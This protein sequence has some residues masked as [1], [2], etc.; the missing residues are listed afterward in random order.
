MSDEQIYDTQYDEV[1]EAE[2]QSPM[3]ELGLSGLNRFGSWVEEEW[4][5]KL[6][7]INGI[8]VYKEMRDNDPII[9]SFLSIKESI[10]FGMALEGELV[11][12]YRNW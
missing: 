8:K 12:V 5:N 11:R 2:S 6:R 1:I 3:T 10:C 4:Y 9:G 7:G